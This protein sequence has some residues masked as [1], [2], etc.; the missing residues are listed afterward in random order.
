MLQAYE[1]RFPTCPQIP[2]FVGCEVVSDSTSPDGAVTKTERRCKLVVEAP[3]LI[4]KIIGVDFV[5]FIQKNV[6]DRRTR[7]LDIEATNETFA[8]RVIIMENCRYFRGNE[9]TSLSTDPSYAILHIDNL[10]GKN[11]FHCFLVNC[12]PPSGRCFVMVDCMPGSHQP[13]QEVHPENSEWTCFEQSSSLDIRA[14][15]GFESTMEKLAMKQYTQNIA[16]G[17]EIIEY[18][19][20]ELKNEGLTYVPPWTEPEKEKTVEEDSRAQGDSPRSPTQSSSEHNLSRKASSKH[21]TVV[22]AMSNCVPTID[23]QFQL[24]TDYIQRYLGQLTLL[25]ESCLVQLREWVANLQRGKV[26]SDQTLLRFLRARDFNVEKARET[27][28]Q[29]LV[30]RKKHQVD[31]IL[32]EYRTPQVVQNYFPG[33]WHHIDKDGRPIYLLRLGQMDVKGLIKS[34]GE[35]GLMQLT[36]HVCEEGLQ[37]MEEITR[38]LG[39]PVSTWSLLVDLEGLNMRHLWRPGIRALLNIIEMVEANYPE[40]M[41]RVLIIRAP[42]VFPILWTLV[43]TFIDEHTRS[44]FLFYGGNDY[45]AAGGL[46]DYI[47]QEYIPDFLGGPCKCPMAFFSLLLCNGST[48]S[49]C[50]ASALSVAKLRHCQNGSDNSG[51]MG[52]SGLASDRGGRMGRGGPV[53]DRNGW[54]EVVRRM[55]GVDKR[56]EVVRQV[57]VVDRWAEFTNLE[58]IHREGEAGWRRTNKIRAVSSVSGGGNGDTENYRKYQETSTTG[59]YSGQNQCFFIVG[60]ATI[61]SGAMVVEGGLVPKGLYLTGSELEKEGGPLTDDSIYHSISLG[62][63]QVHEALIL[64]DDP[65]SVITWDFDVMRQDVVFTVLRTRVPV[66]AHSPSG[67]LQTIQNMNPLAT[68]PEHRSVIDKT[69]KEGQDYF[70]VESP[71]VCHDGESIQGSHVSSHVGTYILQWKLHSGHP[72]D[73]IDSITAPK[74]QIMYY[75]EKLKSADYKGSMSSLQSGNSAFSALSNRSVSSSCPSR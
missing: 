65:G 69:W 61:T 66:L 38:T 34:I 49:P 72:L 53:S 36:L 17:K 15:F 12:K 52:N 23:H 19:V 8:T 51:Q 6:L 26:P 46:V 43:S 40:T 31:R 11:Q 30:W 18:F 20:N 41:G 48:L 25:Q 14:F 74:A 62:R 44:K 70:R 59:N 9:Q 13:D 47:P 64:N 37:L 55:I 3:Y 39:R 10:A 2:V 71:V 58:Q 5:Y 35:E 54:K 28:S 22:R 73:L 1:R 4:K 57:I 67:A 7:T 33:C 68:D 29:S 63:G 50:T 60:V 27:L 42:R 32:S 75:Y 45:Q 16:K 24:E 56:E 21:K